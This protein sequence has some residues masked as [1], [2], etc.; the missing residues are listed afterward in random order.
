T[1]TPGA[2]VGMV[3]PGDAGVPRGLVPNDTNNF[4]PRVG[5]AWDP[6]G[7]GRLSIRA[8]YGLYYEDMR[9]DIWTYPAV[10]QP[11]VI[12]N[13]SNTPFS[14]PDPYR[15]TS[16]PSP[17]VS[18]PATAKFTFP[19][20][21]FTVPGSTLNSPYSHE[22]SFMIEKALPANTILKAGYVGKLEHNLL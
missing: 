19:M 5:V 21:L 18:S 22:I 13:P 10:N 7:N 4:G 15:G 8:G 9:S 16:T 20:G 12:S 14:R 2:P 6:F 3:F 17:Y 11:F 1:V